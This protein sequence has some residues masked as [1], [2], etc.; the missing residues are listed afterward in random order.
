MSPLLLEFIDSDFMQGVFYLIAFLAASFALAVIIVLWHLTQAGLKAWQSIRNSP[1]PVPLS[2]RLVVALL[3]TPAAV[4]S[5]LG[6]CALGLTVWVNREERHRYRE[7]AVRV[8]QHQDS[9][10]VWP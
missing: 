8:Q 9:T 4:L 10:R 5:L 3:L 7:K 6:V 2:R 1:Q